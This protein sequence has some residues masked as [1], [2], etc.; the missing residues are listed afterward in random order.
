MESGKHIEA[1]AIEVSEMSV[2]N[3]RF[4]VKSVFADKVKLEDALRNVANKRQ[5]AG[6][7]PK[8]V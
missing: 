4:R 1:G 3:V 7:L 5:A 8:A 6:E 2:G